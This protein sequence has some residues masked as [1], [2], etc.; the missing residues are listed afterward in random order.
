MGE[1][2]G[3]LLFAVWVWIVVVILIVIG[4]RDFR[5]RRNLPKNPENRK[6]NRKIALDNLKFFLGI[7]G[8]DDGDNPMK[9]QGGDNGTL[10]K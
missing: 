8:K 5:A 9:H 3:D 1:P 4:I 7:K 2:S 10:F 6:A